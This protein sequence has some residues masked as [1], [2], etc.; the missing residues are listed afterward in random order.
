MSFLL[1]HRQG[2]H[3]QAKSS[4]SRTCAVCVTHA[5]EITTTANQQPADWREHPACLQPKCFCI[6]VNV[7]QIT[8]KVNSSSRNYSGSFLEAMTLLK[9]PMRNRMGYTQQK[10]WAISR[11]PSA[12]SCSQFIGNLAMRSTG[13]NGDLESESDTGESVLV[14]TSA[15]ESQEEPALLLLSSRACED[16]LKAQRHRGMRNEG[17]AQGSAPNQPKSSQSHSKHTG[18]SLKEQQA[19]WS[20]IHLQLH[21]Q[22]LPD[23][24]RTLGPF[25]PLLSQKWGTDQKFQT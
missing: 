3:R 23:P 7:I 20:E 21:T 24:H 5:K 10:V 18:A 12:D 13:K 6:V 19:L 14:P 1:L 15:G 22:S 16:R 9:V 4:R 25:A 8:R 2:G 11:C 17:L